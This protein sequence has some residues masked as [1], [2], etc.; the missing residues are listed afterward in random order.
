MKNIVLINGHPDKESFCFAVS[1][2]Y[3]K[4]VDLSDANCKVIHLVD[5]KF[6]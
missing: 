4:G 3:K 2:S 5:L 6:K 1:E